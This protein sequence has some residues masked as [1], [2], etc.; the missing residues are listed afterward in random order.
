MMM[1][2]N[3]E[4]LQDILMRANQHARKQARELGASIYYIKDNKRIREDAEGNMFEI[5]FNSEGNRLEVRFD[6]WWK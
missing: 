5:S 4:Q 3:R 2:T 6:K 1:H